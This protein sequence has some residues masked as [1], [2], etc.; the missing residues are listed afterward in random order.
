[1][2]ILKIERCASQDK[3]ITFASVKC[4]NSLHDISCRQKERPGQGQ[5]DV[6]KGLKRHPIHLGRRLAMTPDIDCHIAEHCYGRSH[7]VLGLSS[8]RSVCSPIDSI[9]P[10]TITSSSSIQQWQSPG[11]LPLGPRELST[12][13][14]PSIPRTVH[15]HAIRTRATTTTTTHMQ[16]ACG[17][18]PRQSI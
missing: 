15:V 12:S 8:V 2:V 7:A 5:R 18:W 6:G 17:R 13:C 9:N 3:T 4:T 11:S 14:V 1:M 16:D 10:L